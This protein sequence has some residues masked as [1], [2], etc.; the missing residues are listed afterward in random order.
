MKKIIIFI[1]I[2]VSI[3]AVAPIVGNR[4]VE[5]R[6]DKE[7]NLLK[8]NGIEITNT[9]K[10][11]TYLNASNHY[12]FL[13]S[14]MDKFL[15]HLSQF[16]QEQLPVYTSALVDG[17]LIAADIKY[18]NIPFTKAISIDI[19]PLSFS[20]KI[21]KELK[22]DDKSF[23]EYLK[24]FL[25]N[26]GILFHINYN[27]VS[28]NFDGFVK[29]IYENHTMKNGS[30]ILVN[31][32]NTKF[33]G[34]GSLLVPTSLDL[35][36]NSLKLKLLNGMQE[37]EMDLDKFS[38]VSSFDSFTSYKSFAKLKSLSVKIKEASKENIFMQITDTEID[39]SS[40]TKAKKAEMKLKN[41]FSKMLLKSAKVNL[42]VSDFDYDITMSDIDKDSL[43]EL[44]VLIS[45]ANTT[46]Q[47][48]YLEQKIQN[49]LINLLS[50]GV[51]LDV[52]KFSLKNIQLNKEDLKGFKVSSKLIL[53][54][55]KYLE[56]KIKY[57]PILILGNVDFD[58][59]FRVSKKIF[60]RISALQPMAVYAKAYAK[61]D[62]DDLV[63][64]YNKVS[65]K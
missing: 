10:T 54:E 11:S 28:G 25:A 39:I 65:L 2:V 21:M 32:S 18:S 51:K 30:N 1:V 3:L 37:L 46:K 17:T 41:S 4:L 52:E 43:E 63:F 48:K 56:Q 16:S 26:K 22:E 40:S 61:E 12:E 5:D 24:D 35:N 42:D 23:Y 7:I 57:A 59:D 19:Y 62:G 33:K 14:D 58:F 27:V 64:V 9:R 8:S 38:S 60:S 13:L 55:D 36:A 47:Y 6:L 53:K 50:K 44:R 15:K 31:L 45:K 20:K 29:D 49:S 34:N